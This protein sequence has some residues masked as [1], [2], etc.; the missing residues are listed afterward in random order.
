MNE[1]LGDRRVRDVDNRQAVD[2]HLSRCRIEG[3]AGMVPNEQDA[4]VAI[5]MDDR[6]I[7]R[8]PLKVVVA[9]QTQILSSRIG[10]R[11]GGPGAAG[12]RGTDRRGHHRQDGGAGSHEASHAYLLSS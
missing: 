1:V 9:D 12:A 3:F 7:G 11:I 8:T 2:L 4:P 10:C 6:L 5:G